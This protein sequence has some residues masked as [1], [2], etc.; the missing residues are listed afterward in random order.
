MLDLYLIRHGQTAP[1]AKRRYPLAGE[2]APLSELGERQAGA[3]KLPTG[4]VF[5]S[6]A[7]RCLQTA[8]LAGCQGVRPRP[9]LR[10]AEFGIMAGHTWA[11]L[12]TA[13]GSGPLSWIE[14]LSDP[15]SLDG[16]P[17]GESGAAFHARVQRWLNTLPP[18]GTVLAF[19]H[20]GPVLAALR[21]CA[22]LRAA[23]V[24]PCGVAHLRRSGAEHA[25]ENTTDWWLVELRPGHLH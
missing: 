13:H 2:D 16:P 20:L 3:L 23:E 14:A 9:E 24:S 8:A 25:A 4:T 11:E 5:S 10:E 15:S 22:G 12:E 1:N 17:G 6:P 18:S 19:T 7:A 21:L